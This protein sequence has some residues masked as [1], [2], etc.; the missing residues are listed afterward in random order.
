VIGI[1][2]PIKAEMSVVYPNENSLQSMTAATVAMVDGI[3][4]LYVAFTNA[5]DGK[6]I[7]VNIHTWFTNN[8]IFY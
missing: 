6:I 7:K 8:D 1:S 5:T 3:H 4:Y 2:T